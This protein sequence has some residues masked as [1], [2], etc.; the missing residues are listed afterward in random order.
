MIDNYIFNGDPGEARTPNLRLWCE[1][2]DLHLNFL[3]RRIAYTN[4]A[5]GRRVSQFH[6]RAI[7]GDP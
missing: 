7:Y 3:Y 1:T 5:K 6:Y 2:Q 4:L